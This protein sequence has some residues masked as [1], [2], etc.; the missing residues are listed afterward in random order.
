MQDRNHILI[1][2]D[3]EQMRLAM[4]TVLARCGYAISRASNGQEALNILEQTQ[5]DCVVSDMKMPVMD[6]LSLLGNIKEKYPRL[7]VVMITAYGTISQAVEAMRKG[8]FD[9]ITKPFSAED[10]E[11]VIEKIFTK[12]S[13]FVGANK[14]SGNKESKRAT[15]KTVAMVTNDPSFKRVLEI[16]G[17]IADS[18]ASVFIQGESGTGKELVSK[19]IH[20]SSNRRNNPFVALNCAA[21]PDNLLE[22]ELFGHEKGSFTG[23]VGTKIGKFDL[24]NSGTILL[25]EI[26]EMDLGLQA[27]LLRVLQEREVDRVGGLRPVAVDVRVIATTNRDIRE[28]VNKG[29]F[30][31]DLYYRLNVIPLYVP[32]LRDRVGDVRLLIEHFVRQYSQKSVKQISATLLKVLEQYSWPG[33]VRELQ[34]ACERAVLLSGD[35]PLQIEHFMLGSLAGGSVVSDENEVQLRLCAGMSVAE[36]EKRLIYETLKSTGNNKTRAAELLG[37]SIRT[38]RNK[39][40]EYGECQECYGD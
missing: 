32:P 18:T 34:N 3:E 10:L 36:A 31:E 2:D 6:G 28:C 1:V 16:S 19:F 15:G 21:L 5:V 8:A 38:L 29:Q 20:T 23:A 14:D 24:A 22:S 25:D 33:N 17:A 27:K 7:P 4:E 9:F 35:A 37:I 39:L 40:N 30:R 12:P 13:Q 11:R 26:S